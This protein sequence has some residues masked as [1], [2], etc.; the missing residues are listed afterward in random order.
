[1]Y[2]RTITGLEPTR[3]ANLVAIGESH[4]GRTGGNECT[5]LCIDPKDDTIS[6]CTQDIVHGVLRSERRFRIAQGLVG[7]GHLVVGG[8]VVS[9]QAADAIALPTRNDHPRA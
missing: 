2:P 6:R 4:Q 9:K 1:M 5:A 8:Q 7:L 3:E